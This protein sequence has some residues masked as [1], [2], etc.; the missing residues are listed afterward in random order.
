MGCLKRIF[1]LIILYLAFV[2]FQSLG[3]V[4]ICK[5][6]INEF[7]HPDRDEITKDS[8]IDI[9]M[10]PDD[11]E[12]VRPLDFMGV[13][14]V[15]AKYDTN[16]QKCI[17]LDTKG[18]IKLTKKDF[19]SDKI[20]GILSN[21]VG[22]FAYQAIRIEKLRILSS[23][24]FQ[25]LSQEIPYV[26]FESDVV[27]TDDDKMYGMVGLAKAPDGENDLLLSFTTN[28]RYDQL[29]SEKFF[30]HINYTPGNVRL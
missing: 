21:V 9:S 19:Y 12:L 7:L 8:T 27:G 14:M 22:K 28:R 4:E 30:K 11:Y 23:G 29:V 5:I 1:T 24:T 26:L 15:I 6:K 10:L 3:G 25:A 16:E 18:L 20:D 2:G 13:K 17:M